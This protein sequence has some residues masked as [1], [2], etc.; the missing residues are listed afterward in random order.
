MT[1]F[2]RTIL[3]LLIPLALIACGSSSKKSSTQSLTQKPLAKQVSAPVFNADSAY[4]YIETQVSFGPRVPNSKEHQACAHYLERK[5]NQLG[6]K[7][8][9]QDFEAV[10]Y[11]GTI[12]NASN[13]IGS[14][15]PDN[16]KRI[17][18][19]AH[20][21]T[22]PWADNDPNPQNHQT[23]ILGANDGASGV[24]VLLEVA[25]QIQ[26]QAPS[27]GID[28]V[29]FDVED[30][31]AP[32][33]YEGEHK[34]EHWCLGSQYWSR[35]PH[36][37]NYNARFGILVDMVGGKNASFYKEGYSNYFAKKITKKVWD[38][39]H[40]LGYG[41]YFIKQEGGAVIDDHLFINQ[42][43]NIKTIDIIPYHPENQ[44]SSFGDT[45][46]TVNDNMDV[47]SKETL[48]A[49]GQTILAIIYNEN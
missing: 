12:L 42:L 18:L 43:A 6:A 39:A 2:S 27:L 35:F 48:Q 38:Q 11:D 37:P 13:L 24:G 15:Q 40:Q 46:H 5:L 36:T 10:A 23:P 1:R 21:D 33:F 8:Y 9:R 3:S 7:V 14:Y 45:W 20:W 34:E 26:I 47:I 16:K 41:Q 22:R 44:Q 25:R 30:Y 32:Q 49:V 29:F 4:H 31:G 17:L 19:C 28:L